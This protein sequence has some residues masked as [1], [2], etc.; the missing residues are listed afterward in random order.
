MLPSLY[1]SAIAEL[2]NG[3]W[4]NA[5]WGEYDKDTA[6]ISRY[7]AAART[8]E[9]FTSYMDSFGQSAVS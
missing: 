1:V 2:K 9:G 5:L 3:A 6:E 7:A 4:P 8:P